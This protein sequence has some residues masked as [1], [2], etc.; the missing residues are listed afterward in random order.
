MTNTLQTIITKSP[1]LAIFIVFWAGFIASLSS[2]T[3]IRIPIVFG[4]VSGASHDTKRKSFLSAVFSRGG[5][6]E[7]E[8]GISYILISSS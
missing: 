3:I 6:S 8:A 7:K 1:I 5:G 4:Y 2:C